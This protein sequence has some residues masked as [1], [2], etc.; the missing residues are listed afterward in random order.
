[1]LKYKHE[2]RRNGL[3]HISLSPRGVLLTLS[4]IKHKAVELP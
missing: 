4:R 2:L 3:G 1:M